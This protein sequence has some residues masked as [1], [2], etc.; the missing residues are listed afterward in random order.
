MP[1]TD[2]VS[3]PLKLLVF[4]QLL[5]QGML[6]QM[7]GFVKWILLSLAGSYFGMESKTQCKRKQD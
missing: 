4:E 5:F 7:E 3:L 6:C 1:L 2:I